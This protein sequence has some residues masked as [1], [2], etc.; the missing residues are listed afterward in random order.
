MWHQM[1]GK[2]AQTCTSAPE[3][4]LTA[5]PFLPRYESVSVKEDAAAG[6]GT[7]RHEGLQELRG[8]ACRSAFA[9]IY[10]SQGLLERD[11]DVI[12]SVD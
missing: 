6:R 7:H 10:R 4:K 11:A 5:A 2:T 3:T 9:V 1:A 8:A 12:S